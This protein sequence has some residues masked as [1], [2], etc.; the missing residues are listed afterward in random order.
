MSLPLKAKQ[1]FDNCTISD[2]AVEAYEHI[3]EGRG[4]GAHHS[5]DADVIKVGGAPSRQLAIQVS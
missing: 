4:Q 1:S 5:R 3:R 2:L